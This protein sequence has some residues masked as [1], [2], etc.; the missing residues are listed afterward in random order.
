MGLAV[1]LTGVIGCQP[2]LPELE[3]E[4]ERVVVG[5]QGD[6]ELCAGTL[7]AWDDHV[8]YVESTLG[9]TRDPGDRIEVYVVDDTE[10]WC[11]DV[12]ACYIGGWADATFVPTY[13]PHAIWHELVHHVVSGSDVGMTDR[14]LSEGLAG[15]LGDSWCPPPGQQWPEPPLAALLARDDIA[16][17]HYPRAAQFVDWIRQERGND[18]L[19]E[20]VRCVDR[21][22]PFDETQACV[23]KALGDDID[24]IGGLFAEHAPA[25]H[26][27]PALCRGDAIPWEGETWHF[28]APLSCDDPSVVDGFRSRHDRHTSVLIDIAQSGNYRVDMHGDGD[29]ALEIEPC[30]CQ[31]TDTGL[32]HA[33]GSN[34]FWVGEPGRYRIGFRTADP[35]TSQLNVSIQLIEP[36][37]EHLIAQATG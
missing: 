16:Y 35:A 27:N 19:V 2:P 31:G 18:A 13:A 10:P 1:C 17:E 23:E 22:D 28:Q 21:G 36:H 24:S 6:I 26:G 37:T 7:R 11:Q 4:G 29:A 30:F 20:L 3:A 34:D 15:S 12:M 14:F 8:E 33:P 9:I 5:V 25:P 32:L